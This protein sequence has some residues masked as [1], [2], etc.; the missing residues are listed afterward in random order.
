MVL[1]PWGGI[2]TAP[3]GLSHISHNDI[4]P[5]S[6]NER[7]SWT[8]DLDIPESGSLCIQYPEAPDSHGWNT[9]IH[10][11]LI[12]IDTTLL[13]G[14]EYRVLDY[15]ILHRRLWQTGNETRRGPAST[16]TYAGNMDV[17]QDRCSGSQGFGSLG[18]KLTVIQGGTA[19]VKHIYGYRTEIVF[20]H[21]VAEFQIRNFS[22]PATPGLDPY[23][24]VG[25]YETAVFGQDLPDA[26]GG[27]ASND[28]PAMPGTYGTVPD[29]YIPGR[30]VYPQTIRAGAG[31]QGYP[32][33]TYIDRTILHQDPFAGIDVDAIGI[34]GVRGIGY[35]DPRDFQVLA[36]DRVYGPERRIDDRDV[37]DGYIV[38]IEK[39]DDRRP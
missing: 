8:E 24:P 7:L 27:F 9:Q 34:G 16:G 25:T 10:L 6:K 26:P 15:Q 39:L 20:H 18:E 28:Y 36:I 13:V 4:L 30:A 22:A 38:A 11:R 32:V 23:S 37:P 12:G 19:A 33:V 3:S 5:S 35:G 14:A 17:P 21:K 31:F 29:S 2:K 1:S